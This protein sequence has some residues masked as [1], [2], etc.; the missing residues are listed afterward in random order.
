MPTKATIIRNSLGHASHASTRQTVI[1][2]KPPIYLADRSNGSG[3]PPCN[4]NGEC[5]IAA[6]V[7]AATGLSLGP[8][9]PQRDD[10]LRRAI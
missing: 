7:D 3:T 8:P 1:A 9:M 10:V 5:S 4:G 2:A 6:S